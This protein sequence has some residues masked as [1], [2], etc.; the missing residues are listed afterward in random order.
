MLLSIVTICKNDDTGLRKTLD[1]ISNSCHNSFPIESIIIDGTVRSTSFSYDFMTYMHYYNGPDSGIYDA[2]NKGMK[3]SKG[4]YVVFLNAG[5]CISSEFQ[6]SKLF[7]YLISDL[8]DVLCFGSYDDNNGKFQVRLP[9]PNRLFSTLPTRH[10]SIFF[11][12]GFNNILYQDYKL[13]GDF[14]FWLSFIESGANPF[15]S[16]Y[17][18]SV[19]NTGGLSHSNWHFSLIESSRILFKHNYNP[20]FVVFFYLRNLIANFYRL[21]LKL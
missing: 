19:F 16:N 8:Y 13:S 9:K 2:M 15:Y 12:R 4:R 14:D 5:D 3:Y 18:F 20:V 10:Q 7:S 1:S 21:V 6:F 11:R 17:I